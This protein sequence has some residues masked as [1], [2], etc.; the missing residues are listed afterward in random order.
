V[1]YQFPFAHTRVPVYC[2]ST[3]PGFVLIPVSSCRKTR[4]GTACNIDKAAVFSLTAEAEKDTR[5]Y[6]LNYY[7]TSWL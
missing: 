2:V 3:V 4:V 6:N 5:P 1:V 7:M